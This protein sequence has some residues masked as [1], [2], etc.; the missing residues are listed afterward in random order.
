MKKLKTF[1]TSR[2]F[3]FLCGLAS[4]LAFAPYFIFPV[5][6]F[7]FALLAVK[8]NQAGHRACF[9]NAFCFGAG[10]GVT[11][12]NWLAHAM[13]LGDGYYAWLVPLIWI[14]FGFVF[15]AYYGVTAWLASFAK[16]GVPRWLAFAGWFCVIEWVRGWAF[17]GFP[18]NVVGN[19]WNGYLPILQSVSV[20]GVYGLGF[21]TVLLFTTPYFGRKLRPTLWALLA[22]TALYG[23]GAW[24]LYDA[25]NEAVW[26]IKVRVV[27]PNVPCT[28][29]WDPREAQNNINKM[30]RLSKTN[31][32]EITHIVWPES[33]VS[34]LINY[35]EPARLQLM[36]AMKQGSV[37][38]TGAMR[39]IDPVEQSVAN[40][41]VVLDDLTNI[42]ASYDKAHLVPFGEY[43]PLRGILPLEKF[44]PFDSDI[45]AGPGPRTI[46]VERAP[47]AGP[48]VCYEAIFSGQVVE[49]KHR[50]QWIINVTNDGW[51]GLSAG[52]HHHFAMA[53]TRAVEEGLPLV[54]SANTGISAV[55]DPYGR[56]LG[57]LGLEDE[58]VI[59][60]P[61]PKAIPPT[62]FAQYGNIIPLLLAGLCILLS[63]RHK[64]ST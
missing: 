42:T 8:N 16:P 23:L 24:R 37:L 17:S 54:R 45:V 27:Q 5:L 62:P 30:I 13:L 55:I 41:L 19:I 34:F 50:P 11:G 40:S 26:G 10:L 25:A 59:D 18:W 46:P 15:G 14:G 6:W 47:A 52:P 3:L 4:C 36:A 63:I 29:K 60:S 38:I 7:S 32:D 58:G 61:L 57:S 48:L 64:K 28:L 22:L 39:G 12:M 1:L 9:F 31:N 21:L 53:Q 49:K 44:V 35:N 51:Y 33:A 56:I 20:I 43:T 2:L